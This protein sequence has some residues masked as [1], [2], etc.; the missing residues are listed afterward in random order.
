MHG[1]C[2]EWLRRSTATSV[3][4]H[5]HATKTHEYLFQL[6]FRRRRALLPSHALPPQLVLT[7]VRKRVDGEVVVV[8]EIVFGL[9][10]TNM[11]HPLFI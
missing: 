6:Q 7:W 9:R 5:A 8:V 1:F 2:A 4:S 11:L 3:Y 10:F